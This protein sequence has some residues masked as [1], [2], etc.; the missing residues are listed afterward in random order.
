M[1]TSGYVPLPSASDPPPAYDPTPATG[2]AAGYAPGT[3]TPAYSS[4]AY[5]GP[6]Q[7]SVGVPSSAYPGSYQAGAPYNV[8]PVGPSVPPGYQQTQQDTY[9]QIHQPNVIVIGGC[10][11][12]RVGVLEDEY[13]CLGIFCAIACFPIGI[14][15]CLA[16][17]QRHCPNCGAV[18]G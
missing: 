5:K 11:A 14:L 7:P 18:F 10:P 2:L 9:I 16:M 8:Y 17:K 1:A 6:S 3:A 13:P 4:T 12:C 15:C